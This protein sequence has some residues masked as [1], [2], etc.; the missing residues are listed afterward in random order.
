MLRLQIA[1]FLGSS[2]NIELCRYYLLIV[3]LALP[4]VGGGC[5]Q[6]SKQHAPKGQ[7]HIAQGTALGKSIP[8]NN[9]PCK[10]KSV[11]YQCFCP[12]RAFCYFLSVHP[13]RFLGLCAYWAFSP[14]CLPF[15][16]TLLLLFE[17][18]GN[19]PQ[20]LK[21]SFCLPIVVL[22]PFKR[23]PFAHQKDSF[24]IPKGLL[25]KTTAKLF[26]TTAKHSYL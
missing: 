14:R 10:G 15:D 20:N 5:S 9:A 25:F 26:R 17:I 6:K 18:R 24:C 19:S 8:N 7:K 12:C 23:T 3:D 1:V 11:N 4:K 2:V 13:R 21:D 16:Y 22:L